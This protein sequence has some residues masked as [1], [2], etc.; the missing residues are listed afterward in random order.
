MPADAVTVTVTF[1][2]ILTTP[3]AADFAVTLPTGGTY[4]GNSHTATAAWKASTGTGAITVEYAKVETTGWSQ[5]AP[6]DAG[7]YKVRLNVA[8]KGDYAAATLDNGGKWEF[9]IKSATLTV[10]DY[11]TAS[12][13]TYGQTLANS[14]LTGGSAVYNGEEVAGTFT[15][16]YP[17]AVPGVGSDNFIQFT[18]TSNNYAAT[19]VIM[20]ANVTPK[21][22]AVVWS[23]A[24]KTYTYTGVD[25]ASGVTAAVDST[26]LVNGDTAPDVPVTVTFTPKA[27]FKDAGSYTATAATTNKN[28]TLTNVEESIVMYRAKIASVTPAVTAP[29]AAE[30]PQSSITAGD[31]YIGTISWE[32]AVADNKFGYN[33]AY[34]ATVVLTPDANHSFSATT[35]APTGWVPSYDATTGTLTLTQTFTATAKA[36]IT[37]ITVT[38]PAAFAAYYADLAAVQAGN[39]LP[40]TA[41]VATESGSVTPALTWN[42][43][44]YN[45]APGATN[46]FTWQIAADALAGY[47]LNGKETTGT[48]QIAN[49][50]ATAVTITGKDATAA[51]DPAQPY[52]ATKLFTVDSNAG[53]ATYALTGGTGIGTIAQGT[54]ML[55]ATRAGTFVVKIVTDANGNYAAGTAI[56]TVTISKVQVVL[57]AIEAKTYTGTLQTATVAA[58]A[59]YTVKTNAGGTDAGNYDVV[60]ALNTPDLYCWKAEGSPSTD[61]TLA[62]TITAVADNAIS[63]LKL[64]NWEYGDTA[65]TPAATAKYGEITYTYAASENG[66][67]T[68]TQPTAAG[69]YWVK[70]A[71]PATANYNE[72]TATKQFTITRRALTLTGLYADNRDYDGTKVIALKGGTL[73]RVVHGD[74]VTFTPATGTVADANA[75][76]ARKA[77]TLP[78]FSLTGAQAG[79]YTLTQPTDE[80]TVKIT[81]VLLSAT[82]VQADNKPYDGTTAATGT[83]SLTGGVNGETPTATATAYTFAQSDAGVDIVVTA[84]GITLDGD[85]GTNYYE[86]PTIARGKANITKAADN[87]ISD[88]KLTNW[89]YGDTASTP[90]A[91][92][93]Y[94]EITYTYAASENGTYTATQPTAA[95]G[96]WVKAAV[97]ATGNYN[98]ATATKQFAVTRKALTA[99]ATADGKTY[100]GT[101]TATGKISLAGVVGTD[102]V[103]ATGTF[104]FADAKAGTD[105]TVNVTAITLAGDDKANYTVNTTATAKADITKAATPAASVEWPEDL[106]VSE[107][108]PL[109]DITLPKNASGVFSWQDASI[110]PAAGTHSYTLIFTPNDVNYAPV[111]KQI[112]VAGVARKAELVNE[113]NSPIDEVTGLEQAAAAQPAG[114]TTRLTVAPAAFDAANASQAALLALFGSGA[115]SGNVV[116]VEATLQ[117]IAL[118]GTITDIGSSNETV[119]TLSLKLRR[120]DVPIQIARVHAGSAALLKQ[121]TTTENPQDGTYYLDVAAG[122]AYVYASKYSLYAVYYGEN[123]SASSTDTSTPSFTINAWVTAG[124]TIS[125]AGESTLTQWAS[126]TYTITPAA[127]YYIKDVKVD[128]V[129]VG[130]VTSYTFTALNRSHEIGVYF[131][132]GTGVG[133]AAATVVKVP[134]TSDPFSMGIVMIFFICSALGLGGFICAGNIRKR[135]RHKG[136]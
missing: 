13:I 79:N 46:T 67:Y 19:V 104:A 108:N 74:E 106:R 71:V 8:A 123:S 27:A 95:G 94:G 86:I 9:T 126:K 62:F 22:L 58:S 1:K 132:K 59:D 50:A 65:S 63:D 29:A 107:G 26:G 136:K 128:G 93:K 103:T 80:L 82:A 119:L 38:P 51:Y 101:T 53:T 2:R 129:S 43:E 120:T 68:A 23:G 98:E 114:S 118:D 7:D 76:T 109:A 44:S 85:W 48:A 111:S 75:S 10:A 61:Q 49:K 25:Q 81:K 92:A 20:R 64:T 12:A 77:I 99:T 15:W 37:G 78:A 57:P 32:P 55:A 21:E 11:P 24:D 84:T 87:A 69:D 116:F 33:T 89:E 73:D 100:D 40:A 39:E 102:K 125:P 90:A 45:N 30:A 31:G 28:Y 60:L 72:A 124:G 105:K 96:Y 130:A 88:L 131:D 14:T 56:A 35:T 54:G 97:P 117:N 112:P 47:D 4:D 5:T 16:Y 122:K 110:I 115:N 135:G 133:S 66:T 52:D 3:T 70:A 34:T 6:V 127:G 83:L 134:A 42:C 113:P 91:T 36:K 18:P 121:V 17:N 41:A